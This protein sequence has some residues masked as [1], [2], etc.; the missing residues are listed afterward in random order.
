MRLLGLLEA[1]GQGLAKPIRVWLPSQNRALPVPP[2]RQRAAAS[3]VAIVARLW[4]VRD[5]DMVGW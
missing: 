1:K 5:G 4:S 2:Y 3:A